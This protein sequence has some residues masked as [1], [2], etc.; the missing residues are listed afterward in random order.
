MFYFWLHTKLNSHYKAWSFRQKQRHRQ[1]ERGRR[2][3]QKGRGK[4]RENSKWDLQGLWCDFFVCILASNLEA[5]TFC[6]SLKGFT[7][8][9]LKY[10]YRLNF[11]KPEIT[12]FKEKKTWQSESCGVTLTYKHA[13][14]RNEG[15]GAS[16]LFSIWEYYV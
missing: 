13:Y 12:I 16:H 8:S 5:S 1:T 10:Q 2:H 4:K 9:K 7:K 3:Q 15:K 14:I 6:D 11:N